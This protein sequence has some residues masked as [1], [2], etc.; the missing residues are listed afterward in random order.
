MLILEVY[1]ECGSGEP[2]VQGVLLQ[3]VMERLQLSSSCRSG[4]FGFW[5]WLYLLEWRC[6]NNSG[7]CLDGC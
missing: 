3:E 7:L 6:T 5:T 2:N 1:V 4:E